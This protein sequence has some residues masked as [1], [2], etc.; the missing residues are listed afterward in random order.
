MY[1][2]LTLMVSERYTNDKT[3]QWSL[4]TKEGGHFLQYSVMAED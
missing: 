4:E 2:I 3:I 1:H